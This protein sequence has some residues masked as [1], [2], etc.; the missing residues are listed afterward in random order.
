MEV[1]LLRSC[2]PNGTMGIK[3]VQWLKLY[4]FIF[5][6]FGKF[7][8]D[9]ASKTLDSD[10]LKCQ[11][12]ADLE[13]EATDVQHLKQQ[14]Q[15][16]QPEI[17]S[18]LVSNDLNKPLEKLDNT[19]DDSKESNS[20]KSALNVKGKTVFINNLGMLIIVWL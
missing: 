8:T 20:N 10:P 9:V 17:S 18:E 15:Q 4:V 19:V 12:K 13:E 14:Q 1:V 3:V 5:T 2:A 11:K 7:K 6:D 16:L